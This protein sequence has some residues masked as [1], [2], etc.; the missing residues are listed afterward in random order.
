MNFNIS[1]R[2]IRKPVPSLVLFVLLLLLGVSSFL[3]LPVGRTP[4][5]DLPLVTVS[6]SQPGA[7]PEELE[8]DVTR[9]VENAVAGLAGIRHISSSVTDG[10]STTRVE[11]QLNVASDTALFEVKSRV[12]A[13]RSELPANIDAPVVAKVDTEGVELVTWQVS[14]P[15]RSLAELS[16]FIDDTVSQHLLGLP[17]IGDAVRRGGSDREIEVALHPDRLLSLG[18]TVGDVQHAL[19]GSRVDLPAGHWNAADGQQ[20]IRILA[21]ARSVREL[22]DTP[23]PLAG[24]SLRLGDVARISD[25]S[26]ETQTFLRRDGVQSAV[27]FSVFRARGADELAVAQAVADALPR[28]R[29]LAPDITFTLI[30]ETTAPT[31]ETFDAAMSTLFEGALLAVVVVFMFLGNWRATLIAAVSLP[32]AI[33]PTFWVLD[34]MGYTLNMLSLLGVT[35]VTGILVDDAIVEIE[36]IERH[37]HMGKTPR[38][39]TFDATAEIGLA[40]MAISISV[41]VVFAPVGFMSGVAGQYFKEF[42]LTVSV[43]VLFSLLV[44]RLITPIM[45]ANILRPSKKPQ[46]GEEDTPV[47]P[48]GWYAHML[49]WVVR[50]KGVVIAF[51]ILGFGL[52]LAAASQLPDDLVPQEET[53]R[54]V[55]ALEAPP[56]LT[57][58]QLADRTDAMARRIRS[59][60]PEVAHVLVEG[61]VSPSGKQELRLATL[62]VHLRPRGEREKSQRQ[63]QIA[64]RDLLRTLP[65]LRAWPLN[66]NLGRE[67]EISVAA[68]TPS[69]LEEAASLVESRM[70]EL[71]LANIAMDSGFIRNEIHITP[72]LADAARLDITTRQIADAVRLAAVGDADMMLPKFKTE[73]RLVPIRVRLDA[74][75]RQDVELL[76]AL[77][78]ARIE[79]QSIPLSAVADVRWQGGP[80]SIERYDRQR[81][82]LVGA[83]LAGGATLGTALTGIRASEE[84]QALPLGVLI[85]PAGDGELLDEVMNGFVGAL[86]LGLL[87]MFAVMVLLFSGLRQPLIILLSLPLALTGAILALY[88]TSTPINLPVLIGILMLMGIVA[89]NAILLVDFAKIGEDGGMSPTDAIVHACRTR[90]RP[91]LMT[92]LAMVAGMLPSALGGAVGG[93]FRSP[94]AVVVI[95]GLLVATVLSLLTTPALFLAVES[96][97]VRFR[98]FGL[99]SPA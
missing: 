65:D 61:G 39:A 50:R 57:L 82:V 3:S 95:G 11:F 97:Y 25:T 83:D 4:N 37:M 70:Q 74:S 30:D 7:A 13:L 40:V 71:E 23:L 64:I 55:F 31:A 81:R 87:L 26:A 48:T 9:L 51:S 20:P 38:Q 75:A 35:L 41:A 28:F 67:V 36:N 19:R 49:A 58:S 88:V 94:M 2:A 66:S 72:R 84:V 96:L 47:S 10:L 99:K 45:A 6:I 46:P 16:W 24:H 29:A 32:L 52:S 62:I 14:S 63:V 33:V 17:G 34:L 91:I 21:R 59:E 85:Q 12:D 5:I 18:A 98:V 77:P 80:S 69:L 8:T 76:R 54:L 86:G 92:T 78:V 89:K 42:G 68:A 22:A 79:G 56:G 44:A 27:A 73:D 93:G 1:A 53:G 43:S 90:A 15:H 60:R